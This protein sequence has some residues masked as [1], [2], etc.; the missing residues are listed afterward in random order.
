MFSQG[1]NYLLDCILQ[2]AGLHCPG[3]QERFLA[4]EL[5]VF[6]AQGHLQ[7]FS[8]WLLSTQP[9]A[10]QLS[11]QVQPLSPPFWQHVVIAALPSP[12]QHLSPACALYPTNNATSKDS[13]AI[14][15]KVFLFMVFSIL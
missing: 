8:Q 9:L 6:V 15:K 10:Q 3:P 7:L 14:I 12:A 5:V 13:I 1:A 2:S 11:L 4:P